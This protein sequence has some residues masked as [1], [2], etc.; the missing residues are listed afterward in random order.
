MAVKVQFRRGLASEWTTAN[1]TLSQ[2][3][4]GY[5]YDTGRF[6]IGNGTSAWNALPYSSGVTGPTGPS[7]TLA[8]GTVTT[9]LAGTNVIITNSGSATNAIFNFTIPRGATGPQGPTGPLGP[10]GP[11][12]IQG[13]QGPTGP[14]GP[15]GPTGPLGP[16]GPQG[17]GVN[18][19]G[20][21]PD[22]ASLQAAHPTGNPGDGYTISGFLYVW[23]A[24][25][26]AWVNVGSLQGPTGAQGA[27]GPTGPSV[28]GPTGPQGLQGLQG[29][30]GNPGAT[31]S[32]GPTGAQGVT[33]PTGSSGIAIATSPITY[34]SPT[35]TVALDI[36]ALKTSLDG[37]YV[38]T[39]NLEDNFG[40]GNTAVDVTPRYSNG[41]ALITS[42]TAYFT[43]FTHLNTVNVSN[44]SVSS[45][46]T[47]TTGAT[48][49]R[50]GLYTVNEIT[51]QLTLVARTSSDTTIFSA[52]NTLYT[53]AFSTTGGYP[54]AYTIQRG[55][56]YALG[57]IV[58]GGTPGNAY[59]AGSGLLPVSMV[60]LAPILRSYVVSQS[61]LPT[62]V[63]PTPGQTAFWGRFS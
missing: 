57:I 12:G 19:L 49:I 24:V 2:G 7:S 25:G 15:T 63:T 41:N 44:I 36:A 60:S 17:T 58:V 13:V 55:V 16:T 59:L 22:L 6:K 18:V 34:D 47:V 30:Q 10:T 50:F 14:L 5:E 1:P 43:Y 26:S 27:T 9:G 48:L 21:Y 51:N 45:A 28:T 29:V 38:V 42:G 54:S 62:T 46:G 33:G 8:L 53:R 20:T 35:Q 3:E 11:Q 4:A 39:D 40:Y 56:R 23:D 32:T 52:I 37:Y 31:G 61:D